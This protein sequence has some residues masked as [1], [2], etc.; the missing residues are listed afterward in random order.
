MEWRGKGSNYILTMLFGA[1]YFILFLFSWKKN[2]EKTSNENERNVSPSHHSLA[3][4]LH[5]Q[6]ILDKLSQTKQ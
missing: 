1:F 5:N 6:K 3:F 2:R 4:V